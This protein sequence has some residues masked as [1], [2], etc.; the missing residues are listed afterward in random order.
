VHDVIVAGV[1]MLAILAGALFNNQGLARLET[2]VDSRLD[3]TDVR[4]DRMQSEIGSLRTEMAAMRSEIHREFEQF[5]RTLGQH[6]ARIDNL[7]KQQ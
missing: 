3:K 5:Y 4:L 1:P 7:E 2:R 6:D